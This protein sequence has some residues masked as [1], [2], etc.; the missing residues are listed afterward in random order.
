MDVV[1]V[2]A[3]GVN[4]D[5]RREVLGVDIVT[6]EDGAGWEAFLG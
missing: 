2:V 5:G 3:A 6:S 4:A 1:A